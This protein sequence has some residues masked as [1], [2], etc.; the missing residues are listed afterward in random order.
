MS[1]ETG[2]IASRVLAHTEPSRCMN[3]CIPHSPVGHS[4]N[5][6]SPTSLGTGS[7]SIGGS[8]W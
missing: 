3:T 5:E 7:S 4:R 2:R 8:V 6:V 1:V